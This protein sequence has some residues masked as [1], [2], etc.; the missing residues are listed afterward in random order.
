MREIKKDFAEKNVIQG[1]RKKEE[2]IDLPYNQ[3][4]RY[5]IKHEGVATIPGDKETPEK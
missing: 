4:K 2:E 5:K 3:A 1:Q